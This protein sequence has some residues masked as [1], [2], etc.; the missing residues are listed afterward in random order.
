MPET[1][2]SK[3]RIDIISPIAGK[4]LGREYRMNT[5]P[6]DEANYLEIAAIV[7]DAEGNPTNQP[8]VNVTAT[9][10]T[11]NKE[12]KGT[13]VVA[14]IYKDEN[15]MVVPVYMFHYEFRTPGD[16][17]ITFKSGTLEKS[18]TVTVE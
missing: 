1:P 3:A 8:T 17:T 9:D 16:H 11:Q 10:S 13:G 4:G 18:E 6:I 15:K 5:G 14:T 7:Y 12:M 2:A